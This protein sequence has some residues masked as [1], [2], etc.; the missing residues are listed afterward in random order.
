MLKNQITENQILK[1]IKNGGGNI[2][3]NY[4]LKN[5]KMGYNVSIKD[6]CILEL[7]NVK[8]ITITANKI[9]KTLQNGQVLGFWVNDNKIYLDISQNYNSLVYALFVAK[10]NKQLAIYDNTRQTAINL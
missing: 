8:K 7:N 9:V 5:F 10:L 3:K 6:I 2:S 1:I 4:R